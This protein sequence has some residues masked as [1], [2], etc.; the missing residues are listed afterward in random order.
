MPLPG[1]PFPLPTDPAA[2]HYG[3]RVEALRGVDPDARAAWWRAAWDE[4]FAALAKRV[5]RP[6]VTMSDAWLLSL[7][8]RMGDA[9]TLGWTRGFKPVAGQD[10]W[11]T[12]EVN[13]IR[14]D[15]DKLAN[16][17][18]FP[19]FTDSTIV[20]DVSARLAYSEGS[21]DAWTR[22]RCPGRGC[23]GCYG[24]GAGCH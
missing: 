18:R 7:I 20:D 12:D 4:C 24:C 6:I 14:A 21:A 1:E 2:V 22:R 23:R 8:A 9:E 13:R 10:Q 15:Y 11:I 19:V 16:G 5:T 3:L 17:E